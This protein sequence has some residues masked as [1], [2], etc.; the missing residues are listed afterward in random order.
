MK[1]RILYLLIILA[2]TSCKK[3]E[4]VTAPVPVVPV[5][6]VL[7]NAKE[8]T[9]FSFTKANNPNLTADVIAAIDATNHTVSAT[10][11][12]G[13]AIT[14]LKAS[15]VLSAGASLNIG[16]AVQSSA[17]T[18]ND[19]TN[20]V[21]FVLI[22][23]NGT[24]Q[25]YVCTVKVEVPASTTSNM[26]IK[27][28]EY[29]PG[30][31]IQTVPIQTLNYT[32]NSTNLL[33]SYKDNFGTYKFDYDANGVLKTQTVY[34][35]ANAITNVLTYT[36]NSNKL[37]I[38]ITGTYG[39]TIE[40]YTYGAGGQVTKYT[41]SY[42]GS[43][44]DTYEYTLDSKNRIK[45]AKYVSANETPGIYS[46]YNYEYFDDVF[47][48]DPLV[49]VAIRAGITGGLDP[50]TGK[51]YALKGSSYQKYN[52]DGPIG[53]NTVYAYT[54]TKNTDGFIINLPDANGGVIFKYTYK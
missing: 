52:A 22:A 31:P 3:A 28:E 27:R 20:P 1:T 23:Q 13:T 7:S 38:T 53:T 50:T 5:T 29:A 18:T 48:P 24:T 30:P 26:V 8:L 10:F 42:N 16:A 47:D 46:M 39:Q 44:K 2:F 35:N 25:S 4:V 33:V 49:K 6:P 14:S 34:D 15:F 21:T 17:I 51:N 11:P 12:A 37:P 43:I 45:T 41:K 32:Y 19:F 54:Y 40:S 9:S 36:M